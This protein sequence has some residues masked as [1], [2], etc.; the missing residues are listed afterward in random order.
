MGGYVG[1]PYVAGSDT[2][3]DAAASVAPH[4]TRLEAVVYEHIVRQGADGSTC[5]EAEVATD[6][7]HQTCS[8][9]V[10]GLVQKGLIIDSG[11]RRPTRSGRGARV[12]VTMTHAPEPVAPDKPGRLR[13]NRRR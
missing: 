7:A 5:D 2:S 10:R 9:R 13:R 1:A 11:D 4:L 6:L 12:Y 8:A 3:R